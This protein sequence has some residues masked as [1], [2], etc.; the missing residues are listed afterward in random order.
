MFDIY[1]RKSE[2][3]K[4]ETIENIKAK[5]F[6]KKKI[7]E[8]SLNRIISPSGNIEVKYKDKKYFYNK[9]VNR[10]FPD[11][12]KYNFYFLNL[13]E[14]DN[15][16]EEIKKIFNNEFKEFEKIECLNEDIFKKVFFREKDS[17]VEDGKVLNKNK[18]IEN[19]I[20]EKAGKLVSINNQGEE[21]EAREGFL[22]PVIKISEKDNDSK[23]KELE[24]IIKFFK[25]N[26]IEIIFNEINKRLKEKYEEL[27]VSM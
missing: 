22:V 6:N 2:L 11:F 25:K 10:L 5:L 27:I 19:Y 15:S 16:E 12:E 23:K 3:L 14:K 1:I 26:D 24:E 13:N 4:S 18:I 7:L 20:I 17:F 8:E 21:I 9:R